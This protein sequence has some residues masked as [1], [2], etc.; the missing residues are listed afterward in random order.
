MP[1]ACPEKGS[2]TGFKKLRGGLIAEL[3]IPSKALR[4]SATSRK[5]RASEA[6]VVAIYN[7]EKKINEGY[8]RHNCNFKYVVGETVKPI[9]V[10]DK[11]RWNECTSG[12]HFFI[13]RQEAEEY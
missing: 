9:E 12:I 11:D 4:S 1:I 3:R 7:A 8:S 6:K 13:T 10:F 2:F 5:C